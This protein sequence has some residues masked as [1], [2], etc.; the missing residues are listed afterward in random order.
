MAAIDAHHLD[1]DAGDR[2]VLAADE[3]FLSADE[4]ARE[5]LLVVVCVDGQLLDQRVQ[6]GRTSVMRRA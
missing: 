2:R 1:G 6:P 3:R 5:L 4:K